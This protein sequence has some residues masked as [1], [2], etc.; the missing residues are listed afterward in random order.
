MTNRRTGIHH[1]TE[2]ELFWGAAYE[3]EATNPVPPLQAHS[4]TRRSCDELGLCQGRKPACAGCT[5]HDTSLLAK[6]AHY[7]APGTIEGGPV[8]R[9][10]GMRNCVRWVGA[11]CLAATVLA[12][13]SYS[14]GYLS[15]AL[16]GAL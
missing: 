10:W 12:S 2:D 5:C 8:R 3:Q 13:C 14:V 4:A 6:G 15:V 7:F 9:R 1:S 16:G 11:A